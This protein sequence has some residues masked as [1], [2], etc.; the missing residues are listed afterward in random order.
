MLIFLDA[1]GIFSLLALRLQQ[2][3]KMSLKATMSL[4]D[5][6]IL[7]FFYLSKRALSFIAV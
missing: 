2:L 5:T 4:K 7:R 1:S 6:Y 3:F